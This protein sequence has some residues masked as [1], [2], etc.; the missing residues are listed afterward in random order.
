M[1]RRSASLA[2]LARRLERLEDTDA[3]PVLSLPD[4]S[5]VPGVVLLPEHAPNGRPLAW[6]E[7]IYWVRYPG[8]EPRPLHSLEEYRALKARYGA[9]LIEP[10]PCRMDDQPGWRHRDEDE[11]DDDDA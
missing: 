2:D 3:V 4:R 5:A 6:R 7:R 10:Q 11:G 8:C 1:T 9:K